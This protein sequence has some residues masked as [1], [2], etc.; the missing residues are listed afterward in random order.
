MKNGP[1]PARLIIGIA[2]VDRGSI[3]TPVVRAIAKQTR[4]PDLVY[5]SGTQ[6]SDF[7]S[8]PDADLPFP[9]RFLTGPKGSCAQRNTIIETLSPTDVLLLMDDDFLLSPDYLEKLEILMRDEPDIVVAT[10]K[11]LADGILGPGMDF[12]QGQAALE[13]GLR[14]PAGNAVIPVRNGY[15]CNMAIRMEP[16]LEHGLRFDEALPLY[17]WF[18]DVDFSVRIGKFG[19]VVR[20]EQLRGVHLGTKTGRTP[21]VKFGYSQ[22]A[23]LVYLKRKG[24]ITAGAMY[25]RMSR[26]IVANLRYSLFPLEWV[27]HRGRLKGNILALSDLAKGRCDPGRI[28]CLQNPQ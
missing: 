2:T 25:N 17:G 16:A 21:G 11:V 24:S 3:V 5:V 28:T 12:D 27:D 8:L 13:A 7:G 9:V 23:N 10:G 4:P 6:A 1:E 20:A 22:V 19:R 15:G 18:E 26:N 14:Q